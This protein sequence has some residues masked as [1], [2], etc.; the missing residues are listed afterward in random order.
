MAELKTAE[1]VLTNKNY[2][3]EA[4][5]RNHFLTMDQSVASGGD[6]SGATPVEY[7]LAAIGGCVSMTLRT[8]AERRGWHIGEVT[9]KVTQHQDENGTYL[10]EE[11]SF[12]KEITE[13]QRKKLI[14]F[15]GKCPV[16]KM[17]KG[18]TKIVT[19]IN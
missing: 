11:I 15:A 14:V 12:E 19:T 7:L 5:T 2:L 18:E 3:A 13:E 1:V 8:Y 6:D 9:V 10:T 16:A 17:V 4:K